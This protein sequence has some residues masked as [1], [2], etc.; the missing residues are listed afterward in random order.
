MYSI[1]V[2]NYQTAE[3]NVIQTHNYK[4][5]GLMAVEDYLFDFLLSKQGAEP[6]VYYDIKEV[7]KA[8]KNKFCVVK[9]NQIMY[10]F[11]VYYKRC[12]KGLLY[13]SHGMEAIFTIQLV[14]NLVER[15]PIICNFYNDFLM[16]E[17]Y[18]R[19]IGEIKNKYKLTYIEIANDI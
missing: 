17:T 15:E 12:D 2:N 9:S 6:V 19:V 5:D 8:P 11:T 3:S 18:S 13:N 7:A 10:M 14:K 1:V 4:Y 16:Y